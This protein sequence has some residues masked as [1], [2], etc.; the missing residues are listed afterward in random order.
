MHNPT[1]NKDSL[2]C[3]VKE[4]QDYLLPKSQLCDMVNSTLTP[5]VHAKLSQEWHILS[6]FV[7]SIYLDWNAIIEEDDPSPPVDNLE[8]QK[9]SGVPG[10]PHSEPEVL[11]E[12]VKQGYP[13]IFESSS[14]SQDHALEA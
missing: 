9:G 12:G 14:E 2:N 13:T 10:V 6:G 7:S 1:P 3:V 11:T 5:L 8:D 4:S